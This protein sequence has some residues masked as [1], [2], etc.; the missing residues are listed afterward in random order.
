MQI[1]TVNIRVVE[2]LLALAFDQIKNY[3][4]KDSMQ[5][6]VDKKAEEEKKQKASADA[7]KTKPQPKPAA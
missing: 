1:N 4:L 2:S 6:R 3:E 5:E 7:Q